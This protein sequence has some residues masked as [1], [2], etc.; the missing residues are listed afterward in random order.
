MRILQNTAQRQ[1]HGVTFGS[2]G[3]TLVAGGSGGFDIWNLL[4]GNHDY[5]EYR[6]TE[7]LWAFELDPLERWLYISAAGSGCSLF[8]LQTRKWSRLPGSPYDHHVIRL[9]VCADGSRVAVSR[10]GAG[11]NRV[12]CWNIASDGSFSLAW[13]MRNGRRLTSVDPIYDERDNWFTEGVAF[14]SS[15]TLLA[16]VDD[17]RDSREPGGCLTHIRSA[18]DGK[19][20]RK[21]GQFGVSVGF[22]LMF[23]PDNSVLIGYRD[24]QIQLLHLDDNHVAPLLPPGRAHF[25]AAAVHPSGRWVTTVGGDGCARFWS[26]PGQEPGKVYKWGTGKLY[27][28]AFSP[29]GTLAAAGSDKGQV[30]VWDVDL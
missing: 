20:R 1:V 14:N 23:T 22:R 25:R 11:S 4:N 26:L 7:Y 30:V 3:N 24:R 12:E 9:S 13:A 28:I 10:G 5:V 21:A 27:S 8:S 18:H 17:P 2:D 15:G 29:D 16:T 19:I 6:V